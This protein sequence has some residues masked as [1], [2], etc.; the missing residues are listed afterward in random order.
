MT[1]GDIQE[2]REVAERYVE[3]GWAVPPR[4]AKVLLRA[5]TL[6]PTQATQVTLILESWRECYKT[7]TAPTLDLLDREIA[8]L[9]TTR[10]HTPEVM[11]LD[12]KF[13]G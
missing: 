2:A 7:R 6:T 13:R 10:N 1:P 12:T 5:C 8:L 9:Q 4:A 3:N 11:R